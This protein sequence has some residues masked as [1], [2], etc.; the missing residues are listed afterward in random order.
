MKD[1]ILGAVADFAILKKDG[2]IVDYGKVHNIWGADWANSGARQASITNTSYIFYTHTLVGTEV[3]SGTYTLSG[4]TIYRQSGNVFLNSLSASTVNDYVQFTS[5]ERGFITTRQLSTLQISMSGSVPTPT[6]LIRYKIATAPF[7]N[8]RSIG[9]YQNATMAGTLTYSPSSITVNLSGTFTPSLT[10]QVINSIA[11]ST[12]G[13][14]IGGYFSIAPPIIMDIGDALIIRS[15]KNTLAMNIGIPRPFIND[16]YILGLSGSG[17]L[18]RFAPQTVDV[19]S[20]AINRIILLDNANKISLLSGCPTTTYVNYVSASNTP[21]EIIN[22]TN[23]S[24]NAPGG[25]NDSGCNINVYGMVNIGGNDVSQILL[26]N[27]TNPNTRILD[28]INYDTPVSI[29][30]GKVLSFTTTSKIVLETL[31]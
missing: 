14:T 24:I 23:I 3:Y 16:N 11:Y 31:L 2:T 1:P 12:G 17:T 20:Y 10:S 4:N 6:Q 25:A 22:A 7:G 29:P 18:Q 19:N 28:V 26:A 13:Q 15:F 21:I 9:A 5:G 8:N 30:A 27:F